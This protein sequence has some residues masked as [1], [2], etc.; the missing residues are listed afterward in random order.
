MYYFHGFNMC[1]SNFI[2]QQLLGVH[3][4]LTERVTTIVKENGGHIDS[5]FMDDYAVTEYPPIVVFKDSNGYNRYGGYEAAHLVS[6][7][8]RRD[9]LFCT[10]NGEAGENFEQPVTSIQIE[11]LLEILKWFHESGIQIVD[12]EEILVCNECGSTDVQEQAWVEVNT[13]VYVGFN[14]DD[15]DDRWCEECEEHNRLCSMKEFSEKMQEWWGSTDFKQMERIT[16]FRQFDF[17]PEDGCQGFVDAC[18]N[19]WNDRT[20]DEK[21]IIWKENNE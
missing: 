2:E 13:K 17:S 5:H 8:L 21:R 14:G 6:I 1:I 11:G 4:R 9:E 3:A 19:W 7:F 20:Y 12:E 10:L 18:N 16:D 15:R